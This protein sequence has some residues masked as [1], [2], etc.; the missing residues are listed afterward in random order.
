MRLQKRT[1][2]CLLSVSIMC[3][4]LSLWVSRKQSMINRAK[5]PSQCIDHRVCLYSIISLETSI[6]HAQNKSNSVVVCMD[7]LMVS[8]DR[9]SVCYYMVSMFI[10]I[11]MKKVANQIFQNDLDS[12]WPALVFTFRLLLCI[13]IFIPFC[14]VKIS[15]I[16]VHYLM[17]HF[18]VNQKLKHVIN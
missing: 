10:H 11:L 14:S 12:S 4:P 15:R 17:L 8:G 9:E 16:T 5:I 3:W 7:D 13:L 1:W 2:W 6:Y 18:T